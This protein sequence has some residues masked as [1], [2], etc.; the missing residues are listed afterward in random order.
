M[1]ARELRRMAERSLPITY[2][3]VAAT[4]FI[5]LPNVTSSSE[6]VTAAA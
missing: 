4:A 2:R 5:F 3:M 1:T 6:S